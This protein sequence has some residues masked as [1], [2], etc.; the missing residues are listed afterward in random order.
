[1]TD[2]PHE[3][4][5]AYVVDALAGPERQEF[6]SHLEHCAACR[7][8]VASLRETLPHL[9]QTLAV[10]PPPSLRDDLLALVRQ[11]PQEPAPDAHEPVHDTSPHET[12]PQD[13][14]RSATVHSLRP[15]WRSRGTALAA[16]AA[17][18]VGG[19]IT[20]QVVDQVTTS[21]SDEVLAADDARTWETTTAEGGRVEVTRSADLGRA[22]LQVEGV[23]DPAEGRTY[24]AWLRDD[25]GAMISAG[26]MTST[27]SPMVLKGD[28]DA[29]TGVGVTV[30]PAGGSP[31]PTSD[32]V[33]LVEFSS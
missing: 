10:E 11:T 2:E 22:V 18:V 27:D 32:P 28:V 20:W 29:A 31:E 5:G 21:V 12:T 30:E 9:T 17:L 26:L 13:T 3:L 6:E 15:R 33:A 14:R 1:M 19:G 7:A 4:S 25:D 16:A 23:P 8:E 24:Q